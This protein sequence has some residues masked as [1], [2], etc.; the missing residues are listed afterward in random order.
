[1]HHNNLNHGSWLA[2]TSAGVRQ[3]K[4]DMAQTMSTTSQSNAPRLPTGESSNLLH[5]IFEEVKCRRA[6]P[7]DSS[8]HV[9]HNLPITQDAF[10]LDGN[11]RSN[12]PMESRPPRRHFAPISR[13][14]ENTFTAAAALSDKHSQ[15]WAE[16]ESSPVDVSPATSLYS[17]RPKRHTNHQALPMDDHARLVTLQVRLNSRTLFLE[18]DGTNTQ[19]KANKYKQVN[20]SDSKY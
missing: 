10:P 17:H 4:S 7:T 2:L 9:L 14:N 19:L 6:V 1:M 16:S 15:L 8:G 11:S 20:S 5:V 18:N 3:A 13:V 12:H